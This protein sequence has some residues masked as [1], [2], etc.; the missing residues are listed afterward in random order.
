MGGAVKGSVTDRSPRINDE[1][2]WPRNAAMFKRI[3]QTIKFNYCFIHITEQVKRQHHLGYDSLRLPRRV[4]G[5]GICP[6]FIF[7]DIDIMFFYFSQLADA[8][9]SPVTAIKYQHDIVGAV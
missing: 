2:R 3:D 7:Y 8:E 5:Q 4:N 1:N 9:G 6:G